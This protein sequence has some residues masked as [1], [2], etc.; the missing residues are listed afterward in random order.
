MSDWPEVENAEALVAEAGLDPALIEGQGAKILELMSRAPESSRYLEIKT[1][2]PKMPP[3]HV[4]FMVPHTRIFFN[5]GRC[6]EFWGDAM[7]ALSVY[8]MT[9]NTP[10]AFFAA[11]ARKLYDNF[12]LLN[13]DE[14]EV[15]H[16]L[17]ALAGGHPYTTPVQESK[18]HAAY[19]DATVSLDELLDSLERKN[20][21]QKRRVG[22]LILS[23]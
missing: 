2:Y 20:V 12:T 9:L 5:V 6:K 7:V 3:G 8:A 16:V 10:A 1:E 19:I 22:Q 15:V 18:L 21:I 11:T 13:E 23:L 17:I 14:A 4:G